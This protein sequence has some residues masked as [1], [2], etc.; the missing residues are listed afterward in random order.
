[1]HHLPTNHVWERWTV[2]RVSRAF[3][4]QKASGAPGLDGRRPLELKHWPQDA[5][6]ALAEVFNGIEDGLLAWPTM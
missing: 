1:M 4:L 6:A 5:R 3:A 2:D